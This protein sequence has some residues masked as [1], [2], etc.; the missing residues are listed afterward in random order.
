MTG[1]RGASCEDAVSRRFRLNPPQMKICVIR[2]RKAYGATV[3][4]NLRMIPSSG[5][6]L[7]RPKSGLRSLDIEVRHLPQGGS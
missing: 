2:L 4:G 5:S 6:R 1:A 3:L 7:I